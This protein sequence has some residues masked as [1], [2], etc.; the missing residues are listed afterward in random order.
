LIF[1][2]FGYSHPSNFYICDAEYAPAEIFKSDNPK[3]FR[4]NG[5]AVF[6]KFYENEGWKFI[7]RVFPQYMI[8]HEALRKR[9]V[10]VECHNIAEVRKPEEMLR[11]LIEKEPKDELLKALQNVLEITA[12]HSGLSTENFGVFGSLLHR[13]YHPNFS[14]IDLI[15]YGG[16]NAAKLCETLQELYEDRVSP[17]M[18]EFE[19]DES[20][21]G[22]SWRF[23]NY[24]PKEFIWHQRRK[25]IY[26]LFKDKESGRIIKTEF[27]P[28][29][30]W[31]EIHA[32]HFSGAKIV[33][34]GWVKMFARITEDRESPFIPSVYGVDPSKI[35]EGKACAE[36]AKRVVSYM[37]EF[38]MQAFKDE[39][40]YVEGNLEEVVTSK[41]SF[42]QV[43]LTYC[44][45]YYEQVLKVVS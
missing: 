8:F 6:Y 10:G 44:P 16:K 38:R 33:Q 36:E 5:K 43:T 27:E 39:K 45:R 29:K 41:G 21:K 1:R 2:V 3:A 19:S 4:T 20:I 22:K 11:K 35:I 14:D 12:K 15:I 42:H 40:V 17:L 7:K 37:E 23:Q 32:V 30:D 18:N 13:F 28:V 24:S 26:A 31:E 34:K 25:M 9:V